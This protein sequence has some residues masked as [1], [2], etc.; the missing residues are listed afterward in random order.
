MATAASNQSAPK[1]RQATTTAKRGDSGVHYYLRR[2]GPGLVTGAANDDPGAIGT[3]AQVGAQFG[4]GSFWLAP[5]TLPLTAVVLEMCAQI[6]NVSG[7][8]LVTILRFHYP[9]WVLYGTISL[10]AFA[11]T[12]S[13]AADLG[14]MADAVRML[15]GGHPRIW[16]VVVAAFSAMLQVLA[17]FQMYSRVLK[18]LALS[19]LA[20]VVAVFLVP[21]DWGAVLR[22]TVVPSIRPNGAFLVA[23]VAVIGTR[24]SPY[25]MV[26]QAA[27]V[28]EQK[29]GDD[30]PRLWQRLGRRRPEVRAIQVDVIAGSVVANLV[31]WAILVTTAGTLHTRGITQL[32]TAADAAAALEPAAGRLAYVLF[33]TGILATGLLAVPVLAGGV[34]YAVGEAFGWARGLAHGASRA[35]RFYSVIVVCIALAAA[36]NFVGIS[37]IRALVL[38]QLVNGLVAIPLVFLVLGICNNPEVMRNRTNGRLANS[39][40]WATAIIITVVGVAAIWQLAG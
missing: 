15:V 13:L 40:G 1:D 39:L 17:E 4:A 24:L 6:G 3:H 34:A 33:A 14:V 37:P 11:N 32:A 10:V 30:K 19:L 8:G 35:P 25:V 16:L 29:I 5:Y 20:Y 2:L 31:T 21:Q 23:V 9:R 22:A 18:V 38:S 28:V 12:I 36:L 27:H 26:W 7:R